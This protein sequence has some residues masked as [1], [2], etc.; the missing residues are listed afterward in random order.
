MSIPE[1][2][3]YLDLQ[4]IQPYLNAEHFV[5]TNHQHY[6][7]NQLGANILH[8]WTSPLLQN[9]NIV[10]LGCN[11]FRGQMAQNPSI[12]STNKV[13]EQLYKMYYW[14]QPILIADIGD[15]VMG[16][17]VADS[18]AALNIVLEFLYKAG[19]TVLVL[20]GSQDLT[21]SQYHA[22][23]VNETMLSATVVDMLLDLDEQET[24]TDQNYLFPLLTG[25]PNYVQQFNAMAFQSYF[26]NPKMIET[27]DRLHFD[28]H[29][30][31]KVRDDIGEMEPIFRHSDLVSID[32]NCVKHSDAPCNKGTSPNGLHGDEICQ[33][34]RYAGMSDHCKSIG[35]YGFDATTDVHNLSAILIAQMIWYF[36]DGV[37]YKQH[38]ADFGNKE[39]FNEFHLNMSGHQVVFVKSKKTQRYWMQLPSKQFIPC[40]YKDY[41][42]A[43]NN[44]I[45]DRWMR[46]VER[47]S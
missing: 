38:E 30:L 43:A 46:E 14:H 35:V 28:C 18:R 26:T 25:S 33:L 34:M 31:G 12:H 44:D 41:V 42:S 37:Y 2:H 27:L 16:N 47:G 22:F 7:D 24:I 17:S 3:P 29:R 6:N 36:I 39:M 13:R 23:A 32:I 15:V 45:P 5:H 1:I 11:E 4:D 21:L 8:D 10:I 19:K 20:G 40:T 9:A